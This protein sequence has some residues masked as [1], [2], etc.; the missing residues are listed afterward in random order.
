MATNKMEF[1]DDFSTASES[2]RLA[3]PLMIEREIPPTPGNYALWY[4]HVREM[5]PELSEALLK[6]FP[7]PGSYDHEK[8]E[9]FFFDFFVRNY[10]PN[11]P[12][13]QNLLVK[14]VSQLAKSISTNVQATQQYGSS[15]KDAMELF[16][17]AVDQKRIQETLTQLLAETA[18]VESLNKEFQ[19]ELEAARVEVEK[20]RKELEKSRYSARYD[21]LTKIPNR[22]YFNDAIVESL[23]AVEEPTCLLLLDLDHF[24]KFNDSYGHLMGDRILEIMGEILIGFKSQRVFVARYGGEEFAVIAND[25]VKSA[26]ALAESIRKKVSAIRI[27]K[28]NTKG[29][30]G[31]VTVSIGL[32]R[33]REGETPEEV[34]ERADV[35]LYHAKDNGRDCVV[36]G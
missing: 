9:A 34:I 23:E 5:S 8:S 14:I 32:V 30:I 24:K 35:A 29:A 25:G 6:H 17:R 19:V 27:K 3:V 4:T 1:R 10:L 28:K 2:L 31:A 36:I 12:K 18:N 33:A 7:G 26:Q 22:S 21:T 11:N 13:A 20:L 15:L 16:E